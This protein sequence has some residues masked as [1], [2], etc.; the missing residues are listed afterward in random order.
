MQLISLDDLKKLQ[1]S[2][3]SESIVNDQIGPGFSFNDTCKAY[4][5]QKP[6]IEAKLGHEY[7][8]NNWPLP[9]STW[10]KSSY[11]SGK[12]PPIKLVG[13]GSSRTAYACLGGK[14]LKVAYSLA[15]VA[16]NIQEQKYSQKKH[17]WSTAYS[18]FAQTYGSNDDHGLLLTE[19]CAHVEEPSQL[20]D[21][22]GMDDIDVLR[23]IV[24]AICDDKGYDMSSAFSNLKTM[25]T[26]Y[27]HKGKDFSLMLG[28]AAI[29]E[30]A[31][32]WLDQL[33]HMK[34]SNMSPGQKSFCQLILFWK[35]NGKN[36][37]LPG[38]VINCE[39]WGFAIR[40]GV[41]APV[42]LDAGFS[43]DVANRY[44]QS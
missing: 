1:D 10:L 34:Y 19:C 22:F 41:I 28:Y 5:N 35:K 43:K 29:A 17:W 12:C 13:T 11:L 21:A 33:I 37:L 42:I 39:N 8:K 26:D 32:K 25:A 15:G 30:S 44:Y 9:M 40:N 27:R 6:K 7:F 20:A 36:E 24:K 16:Q 38:D 4:A 18:C 23:A 14:C 31:A 3:L 2:T